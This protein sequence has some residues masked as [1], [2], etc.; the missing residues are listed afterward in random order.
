MSLN[1][2]I[3]IRKIK[4]EEYQS[5]RSSTGWN[6]IDDDTVAKAL[7]NDLFSVCITNGQKTI[8]IGRVIGDGAIYFYIQDI[9]VLPEYHGQGV[10]KMIMDN[11]ESYL[12]K[13]ACHNSF[14]G[15]MAAEGVHAF[16]NKYGYTKRSEGS[17]GM[18]KIVKK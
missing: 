13:T 1:L 4:T 5:L 6:A 3:E 15:L 9:I 8:G 16:Y 17:P 2:K 14:I 7:Q 11:I 10:G 18:F 12:E